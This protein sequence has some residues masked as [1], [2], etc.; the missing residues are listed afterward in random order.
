M[1]IHITR[2][3]QTVGTKQPGYVFA[4]STLLLDKHA[5]LWQ[6]LGYVSLIPPVDAQTGKTKMNQILL[7]KYFHC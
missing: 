4:E 1:S 3:L 2:T 5:N 7:W 6:F